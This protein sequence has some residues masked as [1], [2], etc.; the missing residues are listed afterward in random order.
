M[1]LPGHTRL[2]E[3]EIIGM[4]EKLKIDSIR[5]L[6]KR[7]TSCEI[8]RIQREKDFADG[9]NILLDNA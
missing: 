9:T 1:S 4:R 7:R 3:D 8:P 2:D 5:Q 6:K